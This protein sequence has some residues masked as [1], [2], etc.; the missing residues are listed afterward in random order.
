MLFRLAFFLPGLVVIFFTMDQLV[1]RECQAHRAEWERDGKPHGLLFRPP[2][3]TYWISG[4]S[5]LKVWLSWLFW[6]PSWAKGDSNAM[7]LL[8][9]YRWLFGIWNLGNIVHAVI[10]LSKTA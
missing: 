3:C 5:S 1:R 2:E 7:V 8:R 9:N 10:V 4:I 6:T